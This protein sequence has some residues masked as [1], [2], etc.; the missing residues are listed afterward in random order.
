MI[1]IETTLS[2]FLLL[3]FYLCRGFFLFHPLCKELVDRVDRL[4]FISCLLYIR[5]ATGLIV[6]GLWQ[7]IHLVVCR[8]FSFLS[9][10][11]P[12]SH[13]SQ[14]KKKDRVNVVSISFSL[15]FF[16]YLSDMAERTSRLFCVVVVAARD[17]FEKEPSAG[18]SACD[19]NGSTSDHDRSS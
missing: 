5:I 12:R 9:T 7:S 6:A 19:M 16:F 18:S 2:F 14:C 11:S 1:W 13:S 4:Q 17:G 10:P 3:P 8:I 15:F